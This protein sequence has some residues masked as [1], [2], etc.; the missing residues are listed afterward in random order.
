MVERLTVVV[1]TSVV[2]N[3]FRGGDI[4]AYY[5]RRLAGHRLVVSF[6]TIEELWFGTYKNGWGERRKSELAQHLELYEVI[7]PNHELVEVCANLRTSAE[8]A[9]RSLNT[10]DAWIAATAIYLNS[11]LASHDRDFSGVPNLSL[12]QQP[13]V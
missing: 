11:P 12:I 10:A 7:W 4:A 1:D 3:L 9:G 5:T 13:R 8:T 2:S 6:Q